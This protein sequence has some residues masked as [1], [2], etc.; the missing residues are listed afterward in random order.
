VEITKEIETHLSANTNMKRKDIVIGNFLGGLAW[1]IGS[2]IG[3][4]VV[5][6][7][8]AYILKALGVF[9]NLSNFFPQTYR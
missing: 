2:V 1:G 8:F 4:G 7:I 5:V 3:A 9:S 6:G